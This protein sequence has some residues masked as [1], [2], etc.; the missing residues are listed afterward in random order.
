MRRQATKS[1][2]PRRQ[3]YWLVAYRPGERPVLIFG[4]NDEQSAREHGLDMLGSTDF[5]IKRYPTRDLSTASAFLRGV[6]LESGEGLD[7]SLQRQTH[8]RGLKLEA[9]RKARRSRY[10]RE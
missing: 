3:Y 1:R 8:E 10:D 7:N 2:A 4:G 5:E 9:R 6:R